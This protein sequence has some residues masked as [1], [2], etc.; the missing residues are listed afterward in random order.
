LINGAQP[1]IIV[2]GTTG[3]HQ[4]VEASTNLSNWFTLTTNMTGTNL[5]QFDDS[6]GWQSPTKF[7]R[8]LVVP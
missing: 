2:T 5:F 7:Y 4:A 3:Q 6:D 1:R 8:A